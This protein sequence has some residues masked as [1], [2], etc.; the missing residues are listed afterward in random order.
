MCLTVKKKHKNLGMIAAIFFVMIG[1]A[2]LVPA[3]NAMFS[4]TP[5]GSSYGEKADRAQ[6]EIDRIKQGR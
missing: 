1:L 5:E 2:I 6:E 4:N 3:F